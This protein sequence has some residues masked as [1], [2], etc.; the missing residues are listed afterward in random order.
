MAAGSPSDPETRLRSV[1]APDAT[2]AGAGVGSSRRKPPAWAVLAWVGLV[3][4]AVGW[5]VSVR[6]GIALGAELAAS[7]AALAQVRAELAAQIA[8]QETV[9][10]QSAALASRMEALASE[11]RRVADVA[12]RPPAAA[13]DARGDAG[14]AAQ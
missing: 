2:P 12:G 5:G 1:P 10:R 9:R 3:V 8:H 11:A 4:C 13:P 7:E 6:S 14:S